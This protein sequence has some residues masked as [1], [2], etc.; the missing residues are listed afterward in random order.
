MERIFF[1]RQPHTCLNNLWHTSVCF[2]REGRL[3][4]SGGVSDLYALDRPE[5]LH[6]SFGSAMANRPND[7][8]M[9]QMGHF[10]RF[11]PQKPAKP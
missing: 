1:F 6:I 10:Y 2:F 3:H 9:P 8:K 5:A 4:V 11:E 7:L